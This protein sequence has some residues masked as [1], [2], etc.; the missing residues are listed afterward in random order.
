MD[1]MFTGALTLWVPV[2]PS[3]WSTSSARPAVE[4]AVIAPLISTLRYADSVR[5]LALQATVSLT[6]M[7]PLP[8]VPPSALWMVTLPPPRLVESVA[9]VMSPPL[10]AMVKSCG[11]SNHCPA[12]PAGARV[13]TC[14]VASMSRSWPEVSTRPPSPPRAPPS[15]RMAPPTRVRE[16]ASSTSDHS[17]TS[18]P[19]PAWL[20]EASISAPAAMVTE[21]AC[22]IAP[23]PCQ[24]PPTCTVPPPDAPVASMRLSSARRMSLPAM[25]TLPPSAAS[26]ETSSVPA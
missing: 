7:S 10:A 4:V 3:P 15:A 13:E 16:P 20:A 24:A 6:K 2:P 11:S 21:S 25:A 23:P 18:P 26:L 17:T 8:A 22:G 12:A 19:S 14:A 9:P 1:S 5:V